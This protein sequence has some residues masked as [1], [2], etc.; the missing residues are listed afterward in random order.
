MN[1]EFNKSREGSS[2]SLEM[3]ISKAIILLASV[4]LVVEEPAGILSE[5][6]LGGGG[7]I[8]SLVLARVLFL[9]AWSPTGFANSIYTDIHEY[10]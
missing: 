10:L 6:L 4:H 1:R 2:F 9:Y 8:F 3:T 7:T 5:V